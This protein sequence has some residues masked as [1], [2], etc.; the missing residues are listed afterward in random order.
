MA[1]RGSPD[2]ATRNPELCGSQSRNL[3]SAV[4]HPGYALIDSIAQSLREE[5][6]ALSAAERRTNLAH[7]LDEMTEL[8][9]ALPGDGFSDSYHDSAIYG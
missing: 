3:D 4:L 8:P 7:L 5:S 2:G 1:R 9:V 6:V